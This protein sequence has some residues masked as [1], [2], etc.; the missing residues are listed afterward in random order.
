MPSMSVLAQPRFMAAALPSQPVRHSTML[1]KL[2][3]PSVLLLALESFP[4]RGTTTFFT[5][6]PARFSSAPASQ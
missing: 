2:R 6:K 1:Q 5:P 3:E 4:L